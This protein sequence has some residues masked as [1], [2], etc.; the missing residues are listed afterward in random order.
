MKHKNVGFAKVQS[1][2]ID[3]KNLT[4]RVFRGVK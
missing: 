3:A 4:A 2:Y 1:S